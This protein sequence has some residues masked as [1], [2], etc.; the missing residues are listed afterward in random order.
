MCRM[1]DMPQTS[2]A[3]AASAISGVEQDRAVVWAEIT[4]IT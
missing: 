1:L 2:Q 3:T 4:A